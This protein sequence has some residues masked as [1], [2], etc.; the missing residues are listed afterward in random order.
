MEQLVDTRPST[1][2]APERAA[3]Y[4]WLAGIFAREMSPQAI[5][6]YRG[7]D[8]RT[9]LNQ[10]AS[11]PPLVPLTDHIHRITAGRE[12]PESLSM[13][14]SVRFA[15]LFLGAGG[16]RSAPPYESVYSNDSNLLYQK[17]TAQTQAALSAF[18]L[19]VSD[20]FPEP[21]DHISVQLAFMAHLA[22]RAG[23]AA[24]SRHLQEEYEVQRVFLATRLLSWI[25]KFLDHCVNA[26]PDGF[27]TTAAVSMVTFVKDDAAHL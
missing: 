2:T 6:T 26:D 20:L 22:R 24:S 11:H 18:G 16:K 9:F 17:Q 7:N 12:S 4:D 13:E 14:L 3:V 19:S 15:S 8:G 10:M 1:L 21:P 27:Y 5:E 23:Q 25:E